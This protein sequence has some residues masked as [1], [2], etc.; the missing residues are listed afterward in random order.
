MTHFILPVVLGIIQGLTEFLPVSSSGH[1]V[2]FQKLFGL[3]NNELFFDICLHAGTL[4]AVV[5]VF[6]RPIGRMVKAVAGLPAVVSSG[7]DFKAALANNQDLR[8]VWLIFWGSLPTAVLGLLFASQAEVVF[9]NTALVGLMLIVTG[10]VLWLTRHGQSGGRQVLQVTVR[11]AL[12]IGLVQGLAIVPGI[13]RSGSTIA[14]AL[15]LGIDRR[16][17]GRFSFLLSLPAIFGA[18]LLGLQDATIATSMPAGAIAA[19]TLAA[20][21]VGYLA[22]VFLLKVVDTGRLYRFAPYCW[23]VGLV[24]LGLYLVF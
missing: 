5:A 1:L 17:A 11:Q 10:T 6:Y 23:T 20:A 19:G 7:G 18:T 24:A 9:G 22:L 14:A 2:L 13:S 8:L 16:V 15:L 3:A 4:V 21:A 12:L